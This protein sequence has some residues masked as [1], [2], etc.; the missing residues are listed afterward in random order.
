MTDT[1]LDTPATDATASLLATSDP[2]KSPSSPKARRVGGPRASLVVFAVV[3]L[4]AAASFASTRRNDV[5]A[6]PA[7][8]FALPEVRE[9]RA[10]VRLSVP[11]GRP[12]VVNLFGAWCEPCKRELPLL[13]AASDQNPDISFIGVDHV[14]GR[15]NAK[16]LLASSGVEFA[17][18]YDPSGTVA[19]AYGVRGLPATM[20]I[21]ADGRLLDVVR[22]RLSGTGLTKRIAALR[23]GRA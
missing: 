10:V 17:A 5:E 3:A 4:V 16:E 23:Q 6:R 13:A 12:T 9:S 7:V 14:D 19:A 18:A 1:A 11:P 21:A 20:F 22:G 2:H 8:A 15:D